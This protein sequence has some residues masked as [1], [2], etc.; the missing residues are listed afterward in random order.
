[1]KREAVQN[2]DKTDNER[3][4][5]TD[6]KDYSTLQRSR[7]E[8]GMKRLAGRIGGLRDKRDPGANR[9]SPFGPL[10]FKPFTVHTNGL[11]VPWQKN[12]FFLYLYPCTNF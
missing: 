6:G 7:V 8:D 1:M 4:E 11:P 10:T 12:Y 5:I 2:V 3:R 9:K